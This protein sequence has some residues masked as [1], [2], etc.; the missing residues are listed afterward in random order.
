VTDAD[1]IAPG[2]LP[3]PPL[4]EPVAGH[5]D[6]ADGTVLHFRPQ[7]TRERW[8]SLEGVWEYAAADSADGPGGA[9]AWAER[10]AGF[11]QRIVVPFPPESQASG[12]GDTGFHP[13]VWYRREITEAD[14][15]AAGLGLQGDRLLL[16]FG[17]VDYRADVWLGDRYV[18]SHEGGQTPFSFDITEVVAEAGL[19]LAL[20]VR[21]EDDPLDV[22]QPRGKQDW[23]PEPHA[24]WYARTTGIWQPVWVEAVPRLHVA[25]LTWRTDLTT[26]SVTLHLELSRRPT[27]PVDVDVELRFGDAE[28]AAARFRV[29]EPRSVLA[30]TLPRQANGQD[31]QALLWTPKN[32]RL[33]DATITVT[34]PD[35]AVDEVAS[36][37]GIRS[38]GWADGHFLLNDR[39]R[40]VRAVLGQGYW[41]TSHLAAPSADALRAEVQ[42]A[43]DLGFDTMRLHQK[44]EDP[45]LLAWADRLGLMLW[46]E[47]PNAFEFSTTAVARLTREWIDVVRRDAS[48]PSIVTWVPINESW[49]APHMAHDPA[50]RAFAQQLLLLTKALDPTRPALSNDG[51]EH[52]G[53]DI[54]TVH[55]YN[56]SGEALR[57]NYRDREVVDRMLAGI[58]PL[59]RRILLDGHDAE[60]RPVLLS[61]FGGV[62]YGPGHEGPGWGYSALASADEYEQL[63]RELFD[64][65]QSSPVLAGFCYTQLSDT[66]QEVNGLTDAARV[67]KLPVETIRSIVLG[68]QVDTAWQ[69]RPRRAVEQPLP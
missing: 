60:G 1:L 17:A 68:E 52:V 50:Q 49:G 18:G 46:A 35:G 22:G 55:D 67:P 21:A 61:E 2:P 4:P 25:H 40:Y 16:H 33:V 3:A 6:E 19:P 39:P 12:I 54:V 69:G 51:W 47:A 56:V 64:A 11:E 7:L 9:S 53:S 15:A 30:L 31:Y 57:A 63:V 58:G 37:L 42:L 34:A 43:K 32:P 8:A 29:V 28:L 23:Q 26:A 44:A 13:V 41:P 38:A 27:A 62:S 65:V 48:H 20:T 36:Y 45:R 24:I 5:G 66:L 59:G 14:V 10:P